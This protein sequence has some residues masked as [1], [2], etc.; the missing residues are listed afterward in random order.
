MISLLNDTT[1]KRVKRINKPFKQY[2]NG[3]SHTPLSR[4]V[5]MVNPSLLIGWPVVQEKVIWVPLKSISSSISFETTYD[6]ASSLVE[7]GGHSIFCLDACYFSLCRGKKI[8]TVYYMSAFQ[9]F[10][11]K[12]SLLNLIFCIIFLCIFL[13]CFLIILFLYNN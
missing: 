4:H 7:T 2:G 11:L 8:W 9:L 6:N 12:F 10:Y 13:L 5:L 3:D 1:D